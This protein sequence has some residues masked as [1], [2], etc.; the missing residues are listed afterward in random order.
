MGEFLVSR[1]FSN[2]R[3]LGHT[4]REAHFVQSEQPLNSLCETREMEKSETCHKPT[5]STAPAYMMSHDQLILH[6]CLP[7]LGDAVQQV[8]WQSCTLSQT[9]PCGAEVKPFREPHTHTAPFTAAFPVAKHHQRAEGCSPPSL[10]PTITLDFQDLLK[11]SVTLGGP[12]GK[13]VCDWSVFSDPCQPEFLRWS[14]T[15]ECS[16]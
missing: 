7:P 14:E 8:R 3:G 4:E 9:V 1:D 15:G 13:E 6:C 5:D 2:G 11:G 12:F 10:I 16:L